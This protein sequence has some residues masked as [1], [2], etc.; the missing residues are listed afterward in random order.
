MN[1][2]PGATATPPGADSSATNVSGE[3]TIVP[4]GADPP[5]AGAPREAVTELARCERPHLIGVRHH[6]PALAVAMPSLLAA[7]RPEVLAIE[8]PAEASEWLG[9]LTH[10]EATAPLAM[11]FT[12]CIPCP[13]GIT[14]AT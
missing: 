10:P 12:W 14:R 2:P 8:L 3:T 13:P 9:W 4:P 7:A 1:T 5:A 6:S 11:A